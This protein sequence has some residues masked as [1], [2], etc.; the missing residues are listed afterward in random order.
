MSSFRDQALGGSRRCGRI[1]G[2]VTDDQVDLGAADRLD[3][4]GGVD[5]VG[6]K[7]DAVAAIDAELSIGSRE[8]HYYTDIDCGRAAQSW[9][10]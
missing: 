9:S 5:A 3:A 6:D 2:C 1:R 10:E 8:R 4:P 7:F